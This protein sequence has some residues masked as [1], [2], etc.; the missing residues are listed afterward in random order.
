MLSTKIRAAAAVALAASAVV[1]VAGIAD[2]GT[3]K[4]NGVVRGDTHI[5]TTDGSTGL[6][7]TVRHGDGTWQSFGRLGDYVGV[8]GLTSA[9]VNGEENILFQYTG[10][11]GKALAHFVEHADGTWN[12]AAPAPTLP[13]GV[14]A[15]GLSATTIDDQLNLVR[16]SGNDVELATLGAD[17]AWS[18]WSA[19]PTTGS[20]S[21][22]SVVGFNQTLHLVELS[23]DGKNVTEFAREPGAAWSAGVSSNLGGY[24][25]TEISAARISGK[26]HVGVITTG[27]AV[28]HG[29][30]DYY[31]NTWG[32]F[33][34]LGTGTPQLGYTPKHIAVTNSLGSLQLVY[35]DSVG[36]MWHTIRYDNGTWQP[37]GA[38]EAAAGNAN[39]GQVSLASTPL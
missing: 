35:T 18:A 27:G 1:A 19:L 36:D 11:Q 31:G 22:I 5:V 20:V 26:V 33:N 8:T 29:I 16:R 24:T 34:N 37:M 14:S 6:V 7:H 28:L 25:A 17:G 23:G 4:P 3:L 32:S 21:S 39:A 10:S 13:A 38:V 12:Y 30:L 2:A 9:L 15:D